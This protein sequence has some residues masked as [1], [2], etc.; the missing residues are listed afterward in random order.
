MAFPTKL[1]GIVNG[2]ISQL[3]PA[4]AGGSANAGA[5]VGLNASGL[6][7]LSML[8]ASAEITPTDGETVQIESGIS[9]LFVMGSAQLASL[10]LELP[11][12]PTASQGLEIIFQPGVSSFTL[13]AP[14]GY[15]IN[16]AVSGVAI[17]AGGRVRT[18]LNGTL[19]M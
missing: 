12:T 17:Y 19:W 3:A 1:L 14:T 8:A 6:I 16:S 4:T 7:D 9:K 13:T 15:S 2:L 5:I 10:T 11:T 18:D